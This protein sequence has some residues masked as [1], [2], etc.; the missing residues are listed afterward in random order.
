MCGPWLGPAKPWSN[1]ITEGV[2]EY[3]DIEENSNPLASDGNASPIINDGST[4][5][6]ED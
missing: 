4:F 1:G 3:D 6:V 5:E 2:E